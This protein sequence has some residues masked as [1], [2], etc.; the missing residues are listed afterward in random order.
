MKSRLNFNGL[1]LGELRHFAKDVGKTVLARCL[2]SFGR[3]GQRASAH[4]VQ[5]LERSREVWAAWRGLFL[6]HTES[7]GVLPNPYVFAETLKACALIGLH[8][9]A[10]EGEEGSSGGQSLDLGDM[11]RHGC[12]VSLE[13]FSSC[14]TS[15]TSCGGEE[16]EHNNECRAIQ[17]V[18]Q[19]WSSEVVAL[20]LEDWELRRVALRCLSAMDLFCQ[21]MGDA[22]LVSFESLGAPLSQCSQCQSSSCG[23]V[24]AAKP[25]S[26]RGRI[27]TT[28]RRMW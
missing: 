1:R 26:H 22:C 12:P 20:F 18:G 27:V 25:F 16:Y 14:S 4:S 11:W 9:L 8:L 6:P 5:P 15:V 7:A 21:E 19:D 3:A 2:A 24:T 17:V 23:L 13:L 10:A 28:R